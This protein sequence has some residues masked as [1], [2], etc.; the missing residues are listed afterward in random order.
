MIGI[1]HTHHFIADTHFGHVGILEQAMR[2]QRDIDTHDR[3]I[4][5][6]WNA[7]VKPTDT[8]WHLGDFAGE[9][10]DFA[11]VQSVFGKLNGIKRLIVGNHDSDDVCTKLAWASV[12]DMRTVVVPGGKIVL[13]HYPFREWDGYFGGTLHFHGHTHDKLKSSKCSWDCGVD[14]QAF[15]PLTFDAIRDRMR[16]LKDLDFSG[17]RSDGKAFRARKQKSCARLPGRKFG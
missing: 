4:I 11:Q 17:C 6:N 12:D 2:P 16:V 5:A 14:Q 7:V 15:K 3:E 1:D 9:E 10:V 8:V 13:R